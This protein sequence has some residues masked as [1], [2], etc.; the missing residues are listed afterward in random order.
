MADIFL[1]YSRVDRP[2]AQII[3]EALETEGLSV[4]WDKIL[5]AGQT[6]DEVTESMLRES[7]VVV[8]LWSQKSVKSTWVR[9]EATQG[10]RNC[11]LVPAMIEDAERPIMFELVQTADLIGWTGDRGDERWKNFVEDLKR[12]LEKPKPA[13]AVTQDSTPEPKPTPTP[14]TIAPA[15]TAPAPAAAIAE[16]AAPVAAPA[17]PAAAPAAKPKEKSSNPLP[18]II[19]GLAVLGIGG[20]FGSQAL[21]GG[22]EPE[23]DVPPVV[24]DP[25]CDACPDLVSLDGGTFTMG[26]PANEANRTGNEGPQRDVTLPAFSISKT[27]V[28]WDQWQ[29]CV[30]AGACN[31][32][33][34]QG[35]GAFPVA[36]VSWD[37][38]STYANWLSQ[39]S[40]RTY[41]LPSEAEWEY[42]ARAGTSTAYW[43]G[44]S[45]SG[46]G[47]VTDA[48]RDT[49]G[50]SENAF[51]VSGMLGNVREWVADCYV[52]NY[53]DAPTDGRPVTNGD[54]GRP[55][56][57]GGSF[58]TG[59]AEH[60][61]ASRARYSRTTKD[62]ALGFR[63]VAE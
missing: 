10:Q 63:V 37:D 28:T 35:E 5:R 48:A 6:Y 21:M 1:S 13:G 41:R 47:I 50:L 54:C 60:R 25:V 18:L 31:A 51:G 42:A 29:L 39:E 11:V 15:P 7:H 59:A 23:P 26:S 14:P 40:G 61:A 4:W 32:A 36:G 46:P 20:W 27:E 2:T 52:N 55:V 3:A 22:D 9:A 43:W 16:P 56:V 8:V 12:A 24:E 44:D 33:Q 49:S 17:Q 57:R 58:K 53:S 38:A 30:D 19:G 45:F 62:R 34:G